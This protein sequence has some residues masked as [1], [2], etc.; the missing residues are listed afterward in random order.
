MTASPTVQGSVAVADPDA[1]SNVIKPNSDGSINVSSSALD[2]H[3]TLLV[4]LTYTDISGTI[5]L[6]GAAQVLRAA[7]A[8]GIE[9]TGSNPGTT[10]LWINDLGGTAAPNTAGSTEIPSGAVFTTKSRSAISI[11]GATTG[12]PFTAGAA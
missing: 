2:P 9:V 11:Y 12:Q 6:G 5:A 1:P 3:Y 8:D 4:G 7:D 10:S